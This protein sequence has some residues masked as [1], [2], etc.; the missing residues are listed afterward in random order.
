MR[1]FLCGFLLLS[2]V[3]IFSG[4]AAFRTQTLTLTEASTVF[5]GPEP[6]FEQLAAYQRLTHLTPHSEGYEESR[7]DYL[8]ERL[9][10]SPYNFVRNGEAFTGLRASRHLK[11]KQLRAHREHLSA[12]EFINQVG[13]RSKRTGEEYLMM[14]EPGKYVP[15]QVIFR[16]ELTMLQNHLSHRPKDPSTAA[17][18]SANAISN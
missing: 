3:L 6:I 12:E 9:A 1:N 13:A 2:L 18:N 16:N 10:R 14:T 5:L 7:I 17:E 15:A 4:C 11:W 8:L